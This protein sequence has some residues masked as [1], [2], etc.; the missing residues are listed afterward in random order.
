MALDNVKKILY[1]KYVGAI[2]Q[3]QYIEHFSM[4]LYNMQR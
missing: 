4:F 1:R 3:A 2:L